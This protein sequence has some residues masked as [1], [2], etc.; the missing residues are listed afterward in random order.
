MAA[1]S[2]GFDTVPDGFATLATGARYVDLKKYSIDV[3]TETIIDRADA[4]QL[5]L[6]QHLAKIRFRRNSCLTHCDWTQMPD[7]GLS[8]AQR[9]AWQVYR[10]QLRDIMNT[11]PADADVDYWPE[12]PEQ[13]E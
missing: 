3:A 1:S 4:H 10:Q 2:V 8:D 11:I 6:Q 12:W 5:E 7:N 9:Q 13:P